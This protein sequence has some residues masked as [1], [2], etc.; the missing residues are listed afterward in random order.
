MYHGDESSFNSAV[1]HVGHITASMVL[2]NMI[3]YDKNYV[4]VYFVH[5]SFEIFVSCMKRENVSKFVT[6]DELM[7]ILDIGTRVSTFPCNARN[8]SK[9]GLI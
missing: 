1:L 7:K 8:G 4:Y 6:N 5:L 3:L 9:N 2:F